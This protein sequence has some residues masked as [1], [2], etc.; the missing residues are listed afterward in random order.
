MKH[1]PA[2]QAAWGARLAARLRV[3]QTT[4][5][6]DAA[7]LRQGLL[8]DEIARALRDVAPDER[9]AHLA[10][11][12]DAFP[13]FAASEKPAAP[14]IPAAADPL[15][16]PTLPPEV[17]MADLIDAA[18]GLSPEQR[19][20]YGQRLLAAGFGVAVA[21]A[22]AAS[23]A[24]AAAAGASFELPGEVRARFAL[25]ASQP[26]DAA[27]ALRL[28][29]LL[30]DLT[31]ALDQLAWGVWKQLAPQS[32]FRRESGAAG[33]FRRLAALYLSGDPEVAS[34]QVAGLLDK[35]RRLVAGLLA[36]LGPAGGTFARGF[37]ERFSPA[38]I[39]APRGRRLLHRRRA[40][41][42]ARVRG[43]VRAG[44]GTGRRARGVERRGPIRRERHPRPE[45]PAQRAFHADA[46]GRAGI[47]AAAPFFSPTRCP[48]PSKSTGTRDCSSSRTISSVSSAAWPRPHARNAAAPGPIPTASSRPRS[49]P[50][51]WKPS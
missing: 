29:G 36:A 11:L 7:D 3:L 32:V 37:V 34:P 35:T 40:T 10:A 17:L 16:F 24:S 44:H 6:E 38:A 2:A 26:V 47:T 4:C 1:F 15:D 25:S 43:D 23:A 51:P 8:E 5:A 19:A 39:E 50:T 20:E 30:A 9:P 42:L 45:P 49:P 28:F 21:G 22:S 18:P 13:E 46:R 12:A 31:T 14:A 41:Q 27:R 33:D 48:P